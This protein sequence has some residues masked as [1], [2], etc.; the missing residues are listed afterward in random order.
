MSLSA[1]DRLNILELVARYGHVLDDRDWAA[2]ELIFTSDAVVDFQ[3]SA[4]APLQGLE[5]IVHH[6]RDIG[7]HPLQH[8]LVSSI[9][10]EIA[11]GQVVVRSKALFPIPGHRA[12][13]G[14]YTDVVVSTS[15]GWRIKHKQVKHFDTEPSPYRQA[16][17]EKMKERGAQ[18]LESP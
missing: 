18:F 17:W 10:E 16:A 11:A 8:I 9:I 4:M 6:Y 13:E 5:S 1:E 3:G 7:A 12:F 2:V 14:L 15:Q